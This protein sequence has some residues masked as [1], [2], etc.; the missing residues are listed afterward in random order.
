MPARFECCNARSEPAS[1][2][3]ATHLPRREDS[4]AHTLLA[5]TSDLV[6][7]AD[8]LADVGLIGLAVMGQNLVLNLSDNKYT[9]AVFNRTAEKMEQFVRQTDSEGRSSTIRGAKTVQELV[10][11]LRSPKRV[12]LMV[13]AGEPVD[14]NIEALVPLLAA[15]DII[16][17]G[18]NSHYLDTERRCEMLLSQHGILFIGAG[19]SGGEE[20]AR[21]GPSIM[22]GGA[23]AAWPHVKDM[24]QAISA[25]V[26]SEHLPM[27]GGQGQVACCNWI[28]KAGSGHFVK[29]VHNGIEYGDMQ[30][31]SEM[32]HV[33]KQ[34]FGMEQ[35]EMIRC[36]EQWKEPTHPLSSYLIDITVDILR[37]KEHASDQT[38]LV[39][40]I[41]D[42]ASQ[43]GTGKWTVQA[44]LDI[45]SPGII[46]AE[47]TMARTLSSMKEHRQIAAARM[48]G[49]QCETECGGG[50]ASGEWCNVLGRALLAAKVV[51]Y[52]QGFHLMYQASQKYGWQLDF[53]TIALLWRGGCIIRSSLLSKI[54]NACRSEAF[55]TEHQGNI[56]LDEYF[57]ELMATCQDSLRQVVILATRHG[58]P[59]PAFSSI[60]SYYDGLRCRRSGANLIQAQRD[61]FGS[62]TYEL[63]DQPGVWIHT[64]WMA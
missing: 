46:F 41:R 62:H 8:T 25:K 26:P 33:M 6:M 16:I 20:G 9:I 39:D 7:S 45:G 1:A 40:R 48:P 32:Y 63:E 38:Y 64:E 50:T 57:V 43:K 55:G 23:P 34:A 14:D 61:Y 54:S 58:I 13:K 36:F 27:E 31:I 28:G 29:M 56:L 60:T 35:A 19:V 24:L 12:W 10:G 49:V 15:G 4:P 21:H 52:M 51:S 44:A 42:A 5:C 18:G 11:M 47:A 22:P 17:D 59:I 30:L 53:P 37:F 2:H 3:F